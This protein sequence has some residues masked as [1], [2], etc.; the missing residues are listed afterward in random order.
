MFI[1]YKH[2][3]KNEMQW[4]EKWNESYSHSKALTLW[5][6][7]TFC[8]EDTH[9]QRSPRPAHTFTERLPEAAHKTTQQSSYIL[10]YGCQKVQRT[11]LLIAAMFLLVSLENPVTGT[12]CGRL[13]NAQRMSAFIRVQVW[14]Y[15]CES[16]AWGNSVGYYNVYDLI[17]SHLHFMAIS[18]KVMSELL[19]VLYIRS[20]HWATPELL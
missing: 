16:S 13:V 12:V 7:T 8:P 14:N 3:N 10:K 5:L 6:I 9:M 18:G 1:L 4:R 2:K 17:L 11:S 20:S 19:A 15:V